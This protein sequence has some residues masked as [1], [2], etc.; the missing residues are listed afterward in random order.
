MKYLITYISVH[1]SVMYIEDALFST[2]CKISIHANIRA[3]RTIGLWWCPIGH[4]HHWSLIF[5]VKFAANPVL[6]LQDTKC[7]KR[8]SL[9]EYTCIGQIRHEHPITTCKFFVHHVRY[10]S[11][12]MHNILGADKLVA[13]ATVLIFLP[14]QLSTIQPIHSCL[15]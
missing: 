3:G 10:G 5:I 4:L 13:P 12:M 6:W 11:F 8:P 9:Y 2:Y 15:V 7:A 1:I 14:R